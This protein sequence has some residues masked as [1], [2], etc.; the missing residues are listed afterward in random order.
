MVG[1][2]IINEIQITHD[3]LDVFITA[4]ATQ[5]LQNEDTL[6]IMSGIL[7]HYIIIAGAWSKCLQH[8]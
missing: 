7:S 2:L 1:N 4:C 6:S 8:R 3:D 5:S